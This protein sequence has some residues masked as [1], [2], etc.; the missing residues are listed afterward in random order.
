MTPP[1]H[2]ACLTFDFDAMSSWITSVQSNNPS[3]ISR[4]EFAIVGLAR[5]LDMLGRHDVRATF[6]VPG[7]TI[8]AYP[9]LVERI[10]AE[11]H[12]L[13]HHGWAHENPAQLDRAR[14]ERVLELGLDAFD[15]VVGQ[16][17]TGYRSP[18]WDLS[19]HSIGLLLAAG[20]TY[21]SSCMANDFSPYYL[22]SGD[23]W[24][25][26]DP[27]VFGETTSLV[28][29]PVSWALDDFPQFEMVPGLFTGFG[30]PDKVFGVWREE[31]DY[32]IAHAPGGILNV[33]MHPEVIGRGHRIAHLEQLIGH[34]AAS[35]A[36]FE[37]LSDVALRWARGNPLE[38]W[39]QA[40]PMRTG[41]D[42]IQSL[43]AV[44]TSRAAAP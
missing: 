44:P 31:F 3:M 25:S 10:A 38:A 30:D 27:Y 17:P 23:R 4:G 1:T 39:K 26:E 5:V 33:T 9:A 7:H 43:D 34:I 32:M 40:N 20:F 21:E 41:R 35:G 24:S 37:S 2:S 19:P 28:E 42:A 13:G 14:E 29:M 16:R 11:G 36:T 18:A 15:R 22:R 6:F 8:L 12:E